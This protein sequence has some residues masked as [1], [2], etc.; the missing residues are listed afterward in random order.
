M[1]I[2]KRR[3]GVSLVEVL[4]VLVILVI[5]IF[6]IARLFPEGFASIN[7]TGNVTMAEELAKRLEHEARYYREGLPD[8]IAARDPVTGA[9]RGDL[10]Q[11]EYF[12]ARPYVDNPI[13]GYTGAPPDDPRYSDLNVARAIIGE[14][15]KVPPPIQFG[16]EQASLYH[17]LFSPIAPGTTTRPTLSAYSGTPMQRV[18]FQDPPSPDNWATLAQLGASGY[19]ISYDQATL[20]FYSA[21]F[22]RIFRI[23]Y[24]YHTGP[25]TVGQSV[26][27]NS[28][29]VALDPNPGRQVTFNLRTPSTAGG[30]VYTP[31]PGGSSL[32]PGSDGLY[33]ALRQVNSFDGDAYEFKIYDTLFGLIGF[34]PLLASLPTAQQD[35]RGVVVRVDYDVDDWH[36]LRQ[37]ETVP[38]ELMG[39]TGTAAADFRVIKL[40]NVGVKKIG[41]QEDII[42]FVSGGPGGFSTDFTYQGLVRY[43]PAPQSGGAAH[44]GTPGIDLVVVDVD[45]G[46]RIYSTTLQRADPG[47]PAGVNNSNGEIDYRNGIIHLRETA[48]W[49]D[50]FTGNAV[51][52]NTGG[53]HVRIYYRTFNDF[54]V[55]AGKPASSYFSQPTLTALGYRQY[56]PTSTGYL[57]FNP[58]DGDTTVTVDYSFVSGSA[59]RVVTEVGELHRLQPPGSAGAPD[60]THWWL[61][62]TH[63]SDAV[64][65][66]IQIG[67]VR[68]ASLHTR[69]AWR[70]GSRTRHINR[71]TLLTREQSR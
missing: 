5:G 40:S 56:T 53:R 4:V 31:L 15:L 32:D 68:G 66:S 9:I 22:D 42:N 13:P 17:A 21:S 3:R 47:N 52:L 55:S 6:A 69:V 58:S 71:S 60:A 24:G 59:G 7:F 61:L 39:S 23:E 41:D 16:A 50:P 14:Q 51:A 26:P 57:L 27:G 36:I 19:G 63:A 25:D 62:L 37:D 28:L 46:L 10:S 48:T 20:Y 8:A 70:E 35:A 54:G 45:T 65:N 33:R 49:T 11:G 30:V 44:P 67:A 34:N 64:A 18:L 2:S 43:Y 38:N 12:Y 29:F 1:V